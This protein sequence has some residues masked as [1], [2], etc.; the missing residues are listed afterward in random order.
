MKRV[1]DAMQSL[2]GRT[3][4]LKELID[5]IAVNCQ[6]LVHG[7]DSVVQEMRQVEELGRCTSTSSASTADSSRQLSAQ[8]EAMKRLVGSLDSIAR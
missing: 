6:E 4:Q 8:T 7:T 3:G 1:S 2:I 5:E